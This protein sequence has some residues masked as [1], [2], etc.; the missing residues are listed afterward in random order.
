MSAFA[1][2]GCNTC[3]CLIFFFRQEKSFCYI[4][5]LYLLILSTRFEAVMS[6]DAFSFKI[7]CDI[8]IFLRYQYTLLDNLRLIRFSWRGFLNKP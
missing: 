6:L 7:L 4:L 5:Q 2:H 3:L 8:S 1:E